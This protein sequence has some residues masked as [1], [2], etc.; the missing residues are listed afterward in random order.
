[1]NSPNQ[2]GTRTHA[3]KKDVKQNLETRHTELAAGVEPVAR[4]SKEKKE[5]RTKAAAETQKRKHRP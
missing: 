4:K 5:E 3:K 2:E 1:M